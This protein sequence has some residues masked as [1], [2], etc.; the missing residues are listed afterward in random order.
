MNERLLIWIA[1]FL[2]CFLL[3]IAIDVKQELSKDESLEET[4]DK[5]SRQ[6][7]LLTLD[8]R[9]A[10]LMSFKGFFQSNF[11]QQLFSNKCN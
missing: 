6:E 3:V 9:E 5:G 4:D 7:N 1:T 11:L 10:R 8:S 2:F